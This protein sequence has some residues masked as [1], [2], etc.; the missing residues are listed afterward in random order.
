MSRRRFDLVVLGDIN[1]DVMISAAELA[2]AFGQREQIVDTGRMVLGGSAVITA[3]AAA[4][5]G[6]RV[7]LA[8]C[9]GAD[10]IGRA[11]VGEITAQGVLCRFVPRRRARRHH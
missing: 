8:G 4:R 7:A 1:P 6:A 2:G 10:W 5:L 3:V 9:V 11:L